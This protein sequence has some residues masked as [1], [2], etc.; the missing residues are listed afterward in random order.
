MRFF[1]LISLF[2]STLLAEEFGS[3]SLIVLKD[4]KA[5]ANQEFKI[6]KKV[7]GQLESTGVIQGKTDDDGYFFSKLQQGSY[8]VQLV[9]KENAQAQVFVRK[10]VAVATDKES[11][12]IVSLK[13][14]NSL[15][16]IDAEAPQDLDKNTTQV[17]ALD[18]GSVLLTLTSSESKKKVANASIFVKGTQVEASSSKDG[19]VELNLPAGEQ[20]ISVIHQDFSAQTFKVNVIANEAVSKLI[21]LTPA[22]MELDEFVVLAP[23]LDG[24]VEAVIAQERNADAVGNVLG[25]EQFGKSGDS[26]V[27][28]A[29]KRVSGIT[30]VGGKYVYVRG[31]GDRYSTVMLNDLHVPSPEPTKRVVPLDIFPT[32]VVE[33]ITI[34]KSYTADLP[35][36]FGGGTVLIKSKDIPKGNDGYAKVGLEVLYND[37]TGKKAYTNS[38][39]STPLPS[40]VLTGGNN[41]SGSSVT[42]DVRTSRSLNL[43]ETT[44]APGMKFEV[45]A[46]KSYE[47]TDN[48]SIGAST[49]LYYKN[50]S[51]SDAVEYNKYYYDMNTESVIHDNHTITNTSVLTTEMAGMINLG[52]DYFENNKVKYTYFTTEKTQDKTSVSTIDYTGSSDDR[53][54]VYLEYVTKNLEMH[55]LSGTN[56]IRFGNHTSGYF[57]NLVIDWAAEKSTAKREEP[58]TV[59]Y[60]YLYETTGLNWDQKNWYYY[61][62]LNDE[63]TNYRADFTLPFEFNDQ[64][65]YTKAGVFIYN[66]TRDFD[67]RRFKMYSSNFN[68]MSED[69]DTIYDT[70]ASSMAFSASYRNTDS[71][72][73][74]QDVTAFYLKQLLSVTH[75]IDV[76]ASM[77]QETSSQQ[78]TDAAD[79]YD[80]LETS[81]LFPSLGVTY[82]FDN[83]DMQLRFS[84]ATSISRPDF[85]EFSNSRYKDPITENIVFGNPELKATYIDHLDL[86]YEWYLSSDEVFSFAIFSKKFTDPIEKVIKLDD[87]QDNTFLETYQNADSATSYGAEIDLRKRFGFI[88]ESLNN[89]LFAT[90]V[91]YINSEITLNS[92]PDNDYTSRLTSQTRSMQG[93]SP[94]VVNLTLGYDNPDSGN[95]ALFL[96]NQIGKRIVSLGTDGNEDVY[97]QPFSKLDFV[98]KWKLLE[99]DDG[100]FF[101]YAIRFKAENLLDSEL[102]FKQGDNVTTSTKPGRYYSLKLDI[103]Y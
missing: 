34:Q 30:I 68:D 42:E 94:Y 77:R 11:Q 45:S 52:I 101:E 48:V 79:T 72:Q 96:F 66:K 3:L 84:Y 70:Y 63:V 38:D 44:L 67:S 32:S 17:Q 33:S 73:A 1:L 2:I 85:R 39:N 65:N 75:D 89:L 50:T 16:F 6:Y 55:Q 12:V 97:E 43:Q 15:A 24:S 49:T 40:S 62:I 14:D 25:S 37:S 18:K 91:A 19:F 71:Y 9:A 23:H 41:V 56:D 35:A 80:P 4:G 102:Q 86:K 98:T 59:E 81:D 103:K 20:T 27:A 93:Q 74:T 13:K 64:D 5:L 29:L 7:D 36:S 61:F 87:S 51:D 76:I 95:S 53:K 54:K 31:L 83:D 8:Q 21:E 99:K 26:S 78:L 46:G 57:D 100:G 60:N 58:G 47:I 22:G 88:D 69:M 92:D 82:R 10:N 28:S 90:N